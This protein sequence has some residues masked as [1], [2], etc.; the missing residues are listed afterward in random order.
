MS[1]ERNP[2]LIP[3]RKEPVRLTG[4][5][6][7]GAKQFSGRNIQG[8]IT[9][10]CAACKNQWH[11]GLP[12]VPE[13]PT[14]PRPPTDPRDVPVVDFVRGPHGEVLEQRRRV[15]PTQEFR[16]GLPIPEGEE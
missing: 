6:K 12:S 15:N 7:C 16:K 10:T 5:P 2:L 3:T 8:M 11:G 1:D 14:V 13:D 9:W 4:C